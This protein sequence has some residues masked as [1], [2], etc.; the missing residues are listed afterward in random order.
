MSNRLFSCWFLSR[1]K[2]TIGYDSCSSRYAYFNSSG[3]DLNLVFE[4]HRLLPL[5]VGV[6]FPPFFSGAST[7]HSCLGFPAALQDSQKV[8]Q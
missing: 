1:E 6:N 7:Q 5:L 3:R 8:P 4:A 2:I